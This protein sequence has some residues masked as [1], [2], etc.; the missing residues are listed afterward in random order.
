MRIFNLNRKKKN[1][2]F[3]VLFFEMKL[4]YDFNMFVF[5]K[6]FERV[7]IYVIYGGKF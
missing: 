7:E 1:L 2:C 6:V 3:C 4:D 5:L